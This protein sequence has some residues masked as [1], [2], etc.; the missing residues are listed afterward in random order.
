MRV[1]DEPISGLK[2]IEP[3]VFKDERGF[4][5]E[6][7][8]L[9]KFKDI[10]IEFEFI[11]D[12]HSRSTKGILRGLHFQIKKPQGKLVRVTRGSVYD[13]AVDIRPDS[14]SYGEWFGIE[15][16]DLN[17]LQLYV[18]QGFAHGFCV[19]SDTADF[20]YKCTEFYYPED[21][22]GIIWNDPNLN[23]A[24]PNENPLVSNKDRNLPCFSRETAIS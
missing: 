19:L 2:V 14:K 7:Y 20:V 23:I 4:F 10:G 11:Q 1:V 12:N 5:L 24:W 21:E 18:P 3:K 13:V 6:S 15:L 17:C 9:N 8:Q 16:S 22:S